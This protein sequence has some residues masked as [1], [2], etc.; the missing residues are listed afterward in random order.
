MASEF[1]NVDTDPNTIYYNVYS[2]TLSQPTI[3]QNF[4]GDTTIV[5]TIN[6]GGGGQATGPAITFSGGSTGLNFTA[7]AGTVTLEGT[8]VV[9]HG[10]TG[11]TTAAGARTNL[12]LGTMA[13]QNANAVAITGGTITGLPNLDVSSYYAV[14]GVQVVEA[15]QPAVPDATGGATIDTE[16]RAAINA[17]LAAL[18]IHGLIDT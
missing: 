4:T 2:S 18:R 12:G 15:Q 7:T 9:A 8:L 10:G 14:A 11:A 1:Y 13:T 3:T 17:L 6:G 5:T 16:A